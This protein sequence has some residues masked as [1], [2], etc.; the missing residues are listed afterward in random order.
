MSRIPS[1]LTISVVFL[2]LGYLLL[3]GYIALYLAKIRCNRFLLGYGISFSLLVVTQIPIRVVGGSLSLWVW[4]V[5]IAIAIL[6]GASWL[7]GRRRNVSVA[8]QK[9]AGRRMVEYV[10]FSAV[11]IGFS[12]YHLSVGAYTEIP[13][14]FWVH[15]GDTWNE[16]ININRGGL[17]G[18]GLDIASIINGNYAPFCMQ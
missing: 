18:N 8:A 12:V 6:L 2:Y 13:S 5:H 10:G 14:D 1:F 3:P 9:S 11:V 4:V 17:P 16:L 15:L 7:Y